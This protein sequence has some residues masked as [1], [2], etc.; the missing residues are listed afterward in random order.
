MTSA[1]QEIERSDTGDPEKYCTA[2]FLGRG[3]TNEAILKDLLANSFY[4]VICLDERVPRPPFSILLFSFFFQ[5]SK[6]SPTCALCLVPYALCLKLTTLP[7]RVRLT[8]ASVKRY[9]FIISHSSFNST[10]N[11]KFVSQKS[12]ISLLNNDIN[13]D[14]IIIC[15]NFITI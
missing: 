9:I 8:R 12:T 7:N 4:C 14:I 1:H 10:K 6:A 11:C 3:E 13:S 2:N 15:K 5:A